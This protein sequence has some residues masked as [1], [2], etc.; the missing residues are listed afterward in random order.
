MRAEIEV[1]LRHERSHTTEEPGGYR[2]SEMS[3]ANS[4]RADTEHVQPDTGTEARRRSKMWV[5]LPAYNEEASLEILIDRID[6]AMFEAGLLYEIVIVD[7][8]SSDGTGRIAQQAAGRFPISLVEH[9][10]NMGL[11]AAIR[12][13][14]LEAASRAEPRDVIV[15]L[16]ADNTHTPD[17]ILRM[18]RLVREG[19]DVVIASRYR[20]GS[21]VRGLSLQRR[22][23]SRM[24]SVLLRTLFPTHGVRDFTSGYRAYR[25]GVLKSIFES[26]GPAFVDQAGFQVM[27][28]ILLKLRRDPH[29]IFGEVPLILR[30]DKK[31]GASKMN[32]GS[33]MR[34]TLSLVVRRRLGR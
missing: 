24:A 6:D 7:D 29:L 9:P 11:G 22:L 12:D 5:V 15:T 1:L 18:E 30:Y 20:A 23:L 25:A 19:H 10:T 31:E 26:Q 28:D 33:T 21:R 34:D 13:G 17:L 27:V 16:D 3:L 2:V 14:L 32:V 4:S 8:G